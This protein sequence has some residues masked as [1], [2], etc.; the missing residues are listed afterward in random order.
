MLNIV[1]F[2]VFKLKSRSIFFIF[3]RLYYL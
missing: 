3:Q 1:M 2:S